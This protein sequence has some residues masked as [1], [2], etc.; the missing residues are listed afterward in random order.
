MTPE[1]LT[2]QQRDE[3]FGSLLSALIQSI[4][5]AATTGAGSL[6]AGFSLA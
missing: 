3:E 2:V 5:S 4:F 1:R 6:Q